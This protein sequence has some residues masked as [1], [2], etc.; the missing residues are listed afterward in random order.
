[1]SVK[2]PFLLRRKVHNPALG[3]PRKLPPGS[4]AREVARLPVCTACKFYALH[5]GQHR[6]LHIDRKCER[7][8]LRRA[9]ETCP[10]GL[11][12]ESNH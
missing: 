10:E 7:L 11:W 9:E 12:H 3:V 6:C 4:A 2:Q 1:M 8:S 5:A